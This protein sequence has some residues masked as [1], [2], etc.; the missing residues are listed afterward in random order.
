MPGL[1]LEPEVVGVRSPVARQLPEEAF[2][3][4]DG[5]RV[6]EQGRYHLDLRHPAALP[7]L[8]RVIDFLVGTLGVGYLKLDYNITVGP[9]TD[10][11]GLSPGVGMLDHNRAHLEWLDRVLDRYPG[12]TIEN[13]SSGGMRTDYAL[14][15]RL[16]LHSTSDQQDFLRYPPSRQRHLPRSRPSRQPSGPTHSRNGPTTRS[17]LGCAAR[18]SG[19]SICPGISI[20]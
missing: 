9:G 14:L 7:H 20:G 17:R 19:V 2:F 13:C 5:Q 6:V 12:L 16:Q 11:G 3:R 8:D 1:W 18:C 4:R 15:S 10:T